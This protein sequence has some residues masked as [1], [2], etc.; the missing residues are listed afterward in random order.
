[1]FPRYFHYSMMAQRVESTG[2]GGDRSINGSYSRRYINEFFF[3][4]DEKKKRKEM[5]K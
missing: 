5:Q 4:K 3:V 1:M 2:T